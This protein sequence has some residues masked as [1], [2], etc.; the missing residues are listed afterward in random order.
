MIENLVISNQTNLN[1]ET[2]FEKLGSL[3][4]NVKNDTYGSPCSTT[5]NIAIFITSN[6]PNQGANTSSDLI[7]KIK[8]WN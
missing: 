2:A 6:L 1:F 3:F 7:S 5:T 4:T 8:T